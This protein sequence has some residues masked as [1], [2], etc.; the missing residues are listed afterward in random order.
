MLREQRL[1]FFE[2]SG[3]DNSY[4]KYNKYKEQIEEIK[5]GFPEDKKNKQ[6]SI[7]NRGN[8]EK[9]CKQY[10]IFLIQ[11][12]K[13]LKSGNPTVAR[14]VKIRM[15]ADEFERSLINAKGSCSHE[16]ALIYKASDLLNSTL[17]KEL[18]LYKSTI[19]KYEEATKGKDDFS[20]NIIELRKSFKNIYQK[21]AC[22]SLKSLHKKL[23]K[24]KIEFDE[25]N[26]EDMIDG[27]KDIK[28]MPNK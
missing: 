7:L 22:N 17:D 18:K 28:R 6:V 13:E 9:T 24:A 14:S 20:K 8:I 21:A 12:Y 2:E 16:K 1:M 25:K 23:N 4:K 19:D 10:S 26:L 11:A 15:E 27:L 3:E 5:N